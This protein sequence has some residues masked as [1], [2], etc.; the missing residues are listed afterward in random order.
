M[1]MNYRLVAQQILK[2]FNEARALGPRRYGATIR[3]GDRSGFVNPNN[4]EAA[5][6]GH[7][8]CYGRSKLKPRPPRRSIA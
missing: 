3:S 1:G 8:P 7:D 4:S 6:Q 2:L 5:P